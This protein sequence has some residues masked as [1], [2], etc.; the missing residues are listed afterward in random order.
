MTTMNGEPVEYYYNLRT[1]M[2][3]RGR[4]SA[5]EDIMGPY[6][7]HDD[8]ERALE[9]AAARN[10]DWDEDDAAWNDDEDERR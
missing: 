6:E 5:W 8:A 1:K 10:A 4:V 7:S 3:E 9:I 2:V